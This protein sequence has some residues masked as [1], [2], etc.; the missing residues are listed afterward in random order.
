ME[1]FDRNCGYKNVPVLAHTFFFFLNVQ[2]FSSEAGGNFSKYL[3][4]NMKLDFRHCLDVEETRSGCVVETIKRS[5]VDVAQVS[6][7]T[8]GDILQTQGFSLMHRTSSPPPPTVTRA[9]LRLLENDHYFGVRAT[10]AWLLRHAE[11]LIVRW[12]CGRGYGG[13]EE[14]RERFGAVV[15]GERG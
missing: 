1:S 6:E 12:G 8:E 4:L 7:V 13:V 3:N 15:A 11:V 10:E 14:E 2:D 9:A 5:R